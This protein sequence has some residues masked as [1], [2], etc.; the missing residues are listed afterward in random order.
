MEG[1]TFLVANA[2]VDADAKENEDPNYSDSVS[3]AD[4]DA[5]AFAT[6]T[7]ALDQSSMGFGRLLPDRRRK[8]A[9]RRRRS[10]ARPCELERR[11]RDPP[12]ARAWCSAARRRCARRGR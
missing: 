5:T 11:D 1:E 12:L 4:K 3:A 7:T 8:C 6:L 2:E 9:H 10:A